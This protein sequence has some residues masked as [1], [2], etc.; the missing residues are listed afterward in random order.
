M[1]ISIGADHRG[2]NLKEDIIEQFKEID[3]LDVGTFDTTRTHYPIYAKRVC[4]HVLNK[5]VDVGIVICG[6]GVG[7]SI[8]A[9]RYEKIYASLCWNEGV[10]RAAKEHDGANV[11]VLPADFVGAHEAFAIC[12]AWFDTT[13]K[14]GVYQDRLDMIDRCGDE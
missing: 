10:A 7:A 8:A 14:G 1:K 4:E 11:L 2:F 13:F 5:N 12:R 6:S 9:N 3:W